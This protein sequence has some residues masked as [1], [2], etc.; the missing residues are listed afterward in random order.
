VTAGRLAAAVP[1]ALA[2]ALGLAGAGSARSYPP[3]FAEI[4]RG[5]EGG[6]V[7]QGWIPNPGMPRF[8]R[9]TLVY[10]P[11]GYDASRRYP[12]LYLLQ[13]FPGSPYQY[14]DGLD[15]PPMRTRGSRPVRW[16]PSS[17]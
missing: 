15:L 14:V 17:P 7:V 16:D 9:S 4:A 11:P 13:G 8:F 10:F 2:L 6:T 1:A 12:V 3:G 5:P